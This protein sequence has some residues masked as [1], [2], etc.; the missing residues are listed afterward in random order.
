MRLR[1]C[2]RIVVGVTKDV[3]NNNILLFAAALSYYFVLA[4]FPALVALAALVA[5]LPIPNLLNAIITVMARVAPPESMALI[6]R[7]ANDVLSPS[8]GALLSAGLVGTLW[9]CSSGFSAAIE[10]LMSPM[11]FPRPG[12]FGRLVCCRWNSRFWSEPW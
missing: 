4:F 8:R 2:K 11:T 7:T 5:Y 3:V 9:T 6:L 12:R 1:V 10:A